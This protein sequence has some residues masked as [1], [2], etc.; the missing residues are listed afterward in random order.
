VFWFLFGLPIS[1]PPVIGESHKARSER[2][3]P[4]TQAGDRRIFLEKVT[5]N[6]LATLDWSA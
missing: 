3:T 6:L 1:E 4:T 5:N 2:K